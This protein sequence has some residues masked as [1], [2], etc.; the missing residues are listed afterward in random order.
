MMRP[1]VAA[2]IMTLTV[3]E[4]GNLI[5]DPFRDQTREIWQLVIKVTRLGDKE[6]KV[7]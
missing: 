4:L 6:L 7:S 2:V 3:T 1:T 5:Y